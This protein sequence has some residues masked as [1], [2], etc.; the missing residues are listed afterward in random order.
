MRIATDIIRKY[1]FMKPTDGEPT[2]W[3]VT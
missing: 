1:P 2:V 3:G